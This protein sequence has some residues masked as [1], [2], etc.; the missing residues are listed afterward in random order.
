MS[1]LYE[2]DTSI[3]GARMAFQC[4]LLF[5]LTFMP[6]QLQKAPQIQQHSA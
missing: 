6:V 4:P 1:T 2:Y 5:A 3:K